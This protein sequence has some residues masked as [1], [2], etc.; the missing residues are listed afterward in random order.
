MK[1]QFAVIIAPASL[2]EVLDT[3]V[4]K[5]GPFQSEEDLLATCMRALYMFDNLAAAIET[6][7]GSSLPDLRRPDRK[8]PKRASLEDHNRGYRERMH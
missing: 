5:A 2:M 8:P 7:H 6:E 1:R 4:E 3:C